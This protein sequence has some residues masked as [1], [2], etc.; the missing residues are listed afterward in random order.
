MLFQVWCMYMV[1]AMAPP[2]QNLNRKQFLGGVTASSLVVKPIVAA[3]E[4]KP[5]VFEVAPGS[6]DGQT[7][8][9]TGAN[10]GLGLE[11]AA[12][13][14]AGG[15]TI[16]ATARSEEKAQFAID[17]VKSRVSGADIRG[18]VL[19][20]ASLDSIRS[21]PKSISNTNIDI[22]MNNAGVMAL[23]DERRT[24][25]GF[26]RQIGINFLG[27]FAL[28]AILMPQLAKKARIINV[29]SAAHIGAKKNDIEQ[30]IVNNMFAPSK[31]SQWGNYCTS[32]AMNILFSKELQR[33]FDQ[34]GRLGS[35]VS[36][37]P[38]VVATDLGRYLIGGSDAAG[39]ASLDLTQKQQAQPLLQFLSYLGVLPVEK[40]ANTQV[41][42]A[43]AADSETRDLGAN[44]G[45]YFDKMQV[46]QSS[47]L[48]QDTDLAY[49]VFAAGERATGVSFLV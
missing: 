21:V 7:V 49:R 44:G 22:L 47:Q 25:D 12:R 5:D 15:A 10:S 16:I 9:I 33:R 26:E 2:S 24:Q 19:D 20:L 36:L 48:T 23:P 29:S 34:A 42:L 4:Q 14:A 8:M 1:H 6:L 35:I 17:T 30:A 27:H 39:S 45:L 32:K 13:L 37:H 28:T 38:G 18:V 41:F 31:Y 3:A 43:A 11:S 46:A 40:G